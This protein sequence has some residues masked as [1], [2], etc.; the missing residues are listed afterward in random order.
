MG[1]SEVRTKETVWAF[2]AIGSCR[3]Q[4]QANLDRSLTGWT[5]GGPEHRRDAAFFQDAWP[6][7]LAHLATRL[8]ELSVQTDRLAS[9]C[10]IHARQSTDQRELA[11]YY[12]SMLMATTRVFN[13]DENN[14]S[15]SDEGDSR[16]NDS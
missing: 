16:E 12:G 3:V 11:I 8:A 4:S 2:G 14:E 10:K 13:L 6:R 5:R 15:E 1:N 9:L 7:H